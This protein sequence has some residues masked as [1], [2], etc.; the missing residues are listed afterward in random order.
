MPS[1]LWAGTPHFL[2]VQHLDG[3]Y[4]LSIQSPLGISGLRNSPAIYLM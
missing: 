2:Y 1:T 3:V 4:R